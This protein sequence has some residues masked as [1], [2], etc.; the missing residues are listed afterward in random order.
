MTKLYTFLC[1]CCDGDNVIYEQPSR[2]DTREQE[3]IPDNEISA[4]QSWCEDCG[5]Y[6]DIK[7]VEWHPVLPEEVTK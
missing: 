3:W 5:D 1:T 6:H 7:R 2:W 4:G